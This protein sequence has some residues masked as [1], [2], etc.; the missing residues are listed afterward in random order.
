ME[1][2]VEV[3]ISLEACRVFAGSLNDSVSFGS[4]RMMAHSYVN[5]NKKDE[6]NRKQQSKGGW[7]SFIW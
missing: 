7:L 5:K 4:C 2:G 6:N 1:V 3:L